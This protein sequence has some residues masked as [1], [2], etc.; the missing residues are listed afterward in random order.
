MSGWADVECVI[1]FGWMDLASCHPILS[2]ELL[3]SGGQ[4]TRL[5]GLMHDVP[6]SID[7]FPQTPSPSIRP[8]K[9]VCRLGSSFPI[10]VPVHLVSSVHASALPEHL[11]IAECSGLE[12]G[13]GVRPLSATR[14]RC[15]NSSL[16]HLDK[17]RRISEDVGSSAGPPDFGS[18][19][20]FDIDNFGAPYVV[21]HFCGA[22]MWM[23]EKVV[24]AS[25]VQYPVFSLSCQQGIIS[26]P[27]RKPAPLFLDSLLNPRGGPLC[28]SFRENIRVYNSL[29]QFTSLGGEIDN[30]VNV[31]PGPYVF[32]LHN[33]TYHRIGHLLPADG[34]KPRFAQ[35]YIYDCAN[36][37]SNRVYYVSGAGSTNNVNRLIVEGLI[38]ML[39]SCNEVVQLFRT[40]MERI[41]SEPTKAVRIRLIRSRGDKPRTYLVPTSSQIGGLIVDDF[42]QSNGDL[43]VIVEHRDGR[44]K[45]IGTVHL[46]YMSLQY[47]I[48][49]PYGGDGFTP[50]I[51][52]V[53]SP[54]KERVV[55]KT[56][57]MR[58]YYAYQL[59][60]RDCV[61]M[62]TNVRDAIHRGDVDSS[63][64][65]KQIILPASFIGGP[66]YLYKKYQ[67][68]MSICRA[69]GY[70]NLIITFTCNGNWPE[71]QA[72]LDFFPDLRL[73]DRPYLVARVFHIKLRHL[74][75]DIMKRGHFGPVFAGFPLLFFSITCSM[76]S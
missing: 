24:S 35:L 68:A 76:P 69:Y 30:S 34:H 49:F 22:Y 7:F 59:Q 36:E 72:G 25:R 10:E 21:C 75:D 74:L 19:K 66:R 2:E 27:A 45:S 50:D 61:D 55:W 40:A 14:K 28:R 3:P 53:D 42:G 54:V 58:E 23:E 57:S 31:R 17:R 37:V 51:K 29:F 5:E 39:D 71:L 56:L 38:N 8:R 11:S 67:D 32:R 60:Q 13:S 46:L 18:G 6:D 33:Q 12:H 73:E 44:F 65:G 43:D 47:P 70:P 9:R 4:I 20:C 15:A 16:P 64:V 26:L 48:L 63:R 62:Y 41:D 1:S 52:Y